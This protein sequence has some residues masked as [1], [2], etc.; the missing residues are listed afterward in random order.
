M[1]ESLTGSSRT[2]KPGTNIQ[3]FVWPKLANVKLSQAS[4]TKTRME[5]TGMRKSCRIEAQAAN[6]DERFSES[7]KPTSHLPL[8]GK[9]FLAELS[10]QVAFLTA[11]FSCVLF[12]IRR[13]QWIGF[14]VFPC[15]LNQFPKQ[16]ATHHQL[17]RCHFTGRRHS[18]G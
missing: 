12:L 1:L 4:K 6:Q 13:N 5:E 2:V 11:K 18:N 10:F 14:L 8:K 16:N 15:E 3:T 7:S 17:D 9:I